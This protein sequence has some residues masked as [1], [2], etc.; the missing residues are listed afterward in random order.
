MDG[1]LYKF[2]GRRRRCEVINIGKDPWPFSGA[3]MAKERHTMRNAEELVKFFEGC[4]LTVYNDNP[5]N[6]S[7][8]RLTVGWGHVLSTKYDTLREGDTITQE[9]ADVWLKEDLKTHSDYVTWVEGML[10]LDFFA[11]EKAAL[12]SL[13]YNCGGGP[14]SRDKAPGKALRKKNFTGVTKAVLLYHKQGRTPLLGLYRRRYAEGLLFQG[15]PIDAACEAGMSIQEVGGRP[16]RPIIKPHSRWTH[17]HTLADAALGPGPWDTFTERV[18]LFQKEKNLSPDGFIGTFTWA[19]I[20]DVLAMQLAESYRE[21][22]L[23]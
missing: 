22:G 18:I 2:T 21:R 5:S 19:C 13:V 16:K 10:G 1:V 15:W 6:P 12:I 20:D 14:L 7:F 8:G 4:R 23:T 3:E 11:H 9:Q 17:W